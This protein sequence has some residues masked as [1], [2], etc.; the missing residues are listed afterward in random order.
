MS[1]AAGQKPVLSIFPQISAHKTATN[2]GVNGPQNT[3]RAGSVL[4]GHENIQ[5]HGRNVL[6]VGLVDFDGLLSVF[7]GPDGEAVKSQASSEEI[8]N[9]RFVVR[10]EDT[11][12]RGRGCR[13]RCRCRFGQPWQH[14]GSFLLAMRAA[15][16][17][18]SLAVLPLG[19]QANFKRF[20]VLAATCCYFFFS[21]SQTMSVRSEP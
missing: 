3:Q 12:R 20:V 15:L 18:N 1:G 4:I 11:G 5:K 16:E 17:V 21:L 13:S 9:R 2:V 14:G 19:I 10:D 6:A 7:R 8:Q